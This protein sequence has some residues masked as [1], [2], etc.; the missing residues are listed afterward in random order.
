MRA[1]WILL[2]L[3]PLLPAGC[4]T[5]VDRNELAAMT[6][7]PVGQQSDFFYMGSKGCYDYIRM[8]GPNREDTYRVPQCQVKAMWRFKVTYDRD[9][10][11][12]VAVVND[13][14]GPIATAGT[15]YVVVV[16]PMLSHFNEE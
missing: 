15:N 1:L 3:I 14:H 12:P 9:R 4:T 2:P 10:W 8:I 11:I 6:Q 7:N 5:K 16:Q 13:H